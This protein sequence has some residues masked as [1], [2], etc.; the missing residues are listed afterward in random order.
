MKSYR[1]KDYFKNDY[2][3]GLKISLFFIILTSS[4]T[5]LDPS[6]IKS[7]SE[8]LIFS[9]VLSLIIG[10]SISMLVFWYS[11]I[12]HPNKRIKI[13]KTKNFNPFIKN[14]F[15]NKITYL[16]NLKGK[17]DTRIWFDTMSPF[18][19]NRSSINIHISCVLTPIKQE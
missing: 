2:K 5:L 10:F 9:V 16:E 7:I 19:V 8:M 17:Y 11:K 3:Y 6:E 15:I 12:Y 1:L 18:T 13:L 4:V 14:N